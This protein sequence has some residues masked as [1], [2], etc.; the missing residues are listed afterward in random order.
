MCR[1]ARGARRTIVVQT[2]EHPRKPDVIL[3][4]DGSFPH[5]FPQFL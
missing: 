4:T 3:V 1:S 2:D 5:G